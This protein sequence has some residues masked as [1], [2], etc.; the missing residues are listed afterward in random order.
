MRKL[1]MRLMRMIKYSKGQFISVAVIVAV[2]LCIYM[3]LNVTAMNLTH[4]VNYYYE[5]TNFNDIHVQVVRISQGA[6]NELKNLDGIK[7][8]QG[9]VSV[10]VPLE[11]ADKNE[12]VKIRLISLPQEE[13]INILYR[14]GK[15]QMKL[16]HDNVILLEQFAAARNIK[17]GDVI[18]PKI[19]GRVF[20]LTV[21][22]I[23]ASAEYVYVMEN[24][25]TLLPTPEKFG[26]AFVSEE[27]AQSVFGYRGSFN[28]LLITVDD[29]NKID[30]IVDRL[31]KKLDQYG[32]KRIIERKDQLSHTVLTQELD[33]LELMAETV[34]VLFLTVAAIIIFIMLS[35]IVQND[36]TGIGVLKALGYS[37]FNILFHYTKYALSMGMVG[38]VI[39][40]GSGLLFSG[41]MCQFYALYFSIPVIKVDI[42]Y[43]YMLKAVIL[44][45][46]FCITAGIFG[47]RPVLK[48]MPADSMRPEAPK[49]G[50]RILL[51]RVGF[52]WRRFSFSWKM[53][54]RN[55]MRTK[56][57]LAFLVF[58][59]SLAYGIN[60]VPLYLADVFPLMFTMQYD[61]YQKMDYHVEFTQPMHKR[62]VKDISH[63]IE[64]DK[65]EPKMEYPFELQNGWRKKTVRIIGI[66]RDTSFY[67]F[68]DINNRQ[69]ELPPKG[70]FLTEAIAKVLKTNRGDKITVNNF[71]PGKEDIEIEVKGI[72]KQYLGSNAYMD[73]DTMGEL[74]VDQEM[75][76]GVSLATKDNTGMDVKEQL[77]D[78]KN[79]ASI[80]SV[81]DM[82]NSF[83]EFMDMM[84][85]SVGV[86]LIF[87]GILS[88]AIIYNATVISISERSMEFASLRVMGF[89]KKDVYRLVGK[90]NA[91][92]TG[93]SIL[94]GIPFG[95]GMMSGLAGAY[96]TEMYTIPLI[97]S[98][99]VFVYAALATIVFVLVAQLAARKKIYHLNFIDALKSRI[100]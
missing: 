57:R 64:V 18:Y 5:L 91:L 54:V 31:E 35:R 97:L 12:K 61:E 4:A 100:S 38:A 30:D 13:K 60:T 36:R 66:P 1:D 51:E 7:E 42:Y 43:S 80:N 52:L 99:K 21:S 63:L 96:T 8:V 29:K 15:R 25:Q 44:T 73:L 23:A 94:L 50:K 65:I 10:D 28:E 27:F 26:V 71:I 11:V 95:I 74:L 93:L 67:K 48:I 55:V 2:A 24:E 34:P 79:I 98:P 6:T 32:L 58:G 3:L 70:I 85:V 53:V 72:V 62:V 46:F 82:K 49:S 59:L 33:G 39:G 76:T 37:N 92:I 56:G 88:F 14:L 19:N 17:P 83:L 84:M 68:E 47:A 86:L 78:I 45:G 77:Q 40:I 89:D 41:P 87:G 22:G 9:R 81:T 69:V 90:E 75:I 20:E 16:A